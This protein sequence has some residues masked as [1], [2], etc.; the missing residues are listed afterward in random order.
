[1]KSTSKFIALGI[2]ITIT[3]T[4]SCFTYGYF[5]D[6]EIQNNQITFNTKSTLLGV[7]VSDSKY[8]TY[9][10]NEVIKFKYMLKS[11][12][13]SNRKMY[14]GEELVLE[15]TPDSADMFKGASINFYKT[16][17]DGNYGYIE[18]VK[19][20]FYKIGDWDVIGDSRTVGIKAYIKGLDG[21]IRNAWSSGKEVRYFSVTL[22]GYTTSAIDPGKVEI[23]EVSNSKHELDKE[24]DNIDIV[25]PQEEEML[26]PSEPDIVKPPEEDILEPS[27][28]DI[29]EPPE[30]DI[31][32]KNDSDIVP[33][34]KE[35]V[36]I[37]SKP[38]IKLPSK[39]E[40]QE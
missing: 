15:I 33:P 23:I 4:S 25:K 35:E 9:R 20:S 1:M 29:V 8:I 16:D 36:I 14:P 17:D 28:P 2:G 11:E 22:K 5:T 26:E 39:E 38:D 3:F 21:N 31:L 13:L 6:I 30:E 7:D 32:E 19:D 10:G 40:I 34:P 24:A 18:M 12:N 37:P 27:E